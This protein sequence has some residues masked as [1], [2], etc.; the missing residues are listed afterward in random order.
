MDI[1]LPYSIKQTKH[2]IMKSIKVEVFN[3]STKW[4]NT[5]E[6]H[7]ATGINKVLGSSI[8]R[9]FEFNSRLREFNSNHF[10][11][12][13]SLSIVISSEGSILFDSYVLNEELNFKLRFGNTA[14]SKRKF[15]KQLHSM[16]SWSCDPIKVMSLDELI[17]SLVD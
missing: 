8:N 16:L 12:N 4:V 17:T 7:S 1:Y 14:K 11:A 5:I 2:H 10:K 3:G 13:D 6:L 9:L 15:A